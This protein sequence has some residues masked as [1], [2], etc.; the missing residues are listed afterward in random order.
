MQEESVAQRRRLAVSPAQ[1]EELVAHRDHDPRP[2]VRERCAALVKIADGMSPHAVAQ[3]GL[4]KARDPDT[5]YGWLTTYS[6]EA[7]GLAGVVARQHGGARRGC[8]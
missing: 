6:A 1:H 8:L 3:R 5:V 7:R 2:Y 4:L